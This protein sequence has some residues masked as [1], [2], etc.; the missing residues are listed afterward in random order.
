M[1][2]VREVSDE[3]TFYGLESQWR[4]LE[5]CAA[6]DNPFLAFEWLTALWHHFGSRYRL[7]ILL[8]EQDG[9]VIGIAPL[10]LAKRFGF[11]RLQFLGRP[12]S[13]YSD[14]L[15]GDHRETCLAE[16]LDYIHR[17][18]SWDQLDL[19]GIP[20]TSPNLPI[21]QSLWAQRTLVSRWS[22]HL[23]APYVPISTSWQEYLSTLKPKLRSDTA[24]QI[25]RLERQGQVSF[26]RCADQEEAL[27]LLDIMAAQKSSRY[28]TTGARDILRNGTTLAFF[29]EAVRGMWA[30]GDVDISCLSLDRK[31]VA[32]HF[33]FRSQDKFFHY[34]PSFDHRYGRYA[35]GRL[36]NYHLLEVSFRDGLKEFDFLAGGEAYKYDWTQHQRR[37]HRLTS[38]RRAPKGM[39]LYTKQEIVMASARRSAGARGLVRWGRQAS[40]RLTALREKP[41]R[42]QGSNGGPTSTD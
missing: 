13:D 18:L 5:R 33:G 38:Y 12:F 7:R 1:I 39:A 14:F 26:Q 32:I 22:A 34:M 24:R 16:F 6:N 15:I 30:R 42:R 40:A 8:A 11:T 9:T 31:P 35:V 20:E 21:L 17:R 2:T 36:L 27:H 28:R 10:M 19:E 29:K 41:Y 4:E 23:L 37:I 3:R 25:R